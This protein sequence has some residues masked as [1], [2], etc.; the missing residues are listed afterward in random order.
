MGDTLIAIRSW[1]LLLM[2]LVVAAACS[3]RKEGVRGDGLV[4]RP[5]ERRVCLEPG[6]PNTGKDRCYKL[7]DDAEIESSIESGDPVSVR[8]VDGLAVSVQGFPLDD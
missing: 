5:T 2:L 1:A 4:T 7:A 3:Q 8:S 6:D